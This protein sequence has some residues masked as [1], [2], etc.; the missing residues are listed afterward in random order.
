MR[1]AKQPPSIKSHLGGF[2]FEAKGQMYITLASSV[3]I[4]GLNF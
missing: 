3:K 1:E 2:L 4:T